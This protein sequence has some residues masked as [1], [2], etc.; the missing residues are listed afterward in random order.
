MI[1][2]FV[3]K[4]GHVAT[5]AL[6]NCPA[7][8]SDWYTTIFLPEVID[9]LGKNKHKRR[10]ISHHDNASSHTAKQTNTFLRKKNEELMSNLAYSPDLAS[11][12]SQKIKNQLRGQRF[13]SPE[14]AVEEY[15]NMLPRPPERSGLV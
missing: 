8:N 12:E 2:S 9:K 14:K 6:D 7:V 10:I 13:S 5:V 4:T 11:S 3:N 15:E 1:A